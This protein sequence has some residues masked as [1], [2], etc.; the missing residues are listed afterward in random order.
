LAP[1]QLPSAVTAVARRVDASCSLPVPH[2]CE[3]PDVLAARFD[4]PQRL[5]RVSVEDWARMPM[6][7]C[8]MCWR[9]AHVSQALGQDDVRAAIPALYAVTN[10]AGHRL[11]P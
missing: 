9:I 7:G 10:D 2:A 1:L 5:Q 6:A 3:G 8:P 4:V 11:A